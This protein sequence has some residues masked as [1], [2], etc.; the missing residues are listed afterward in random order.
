MILNSDL[1]DDNKIC[2]DMLNIYVEYLILI[3]YNFNE[4]NFSIN[5]FGLLK[6]SLK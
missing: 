6:K 5:F 3:L 1:N 4:N 2:K